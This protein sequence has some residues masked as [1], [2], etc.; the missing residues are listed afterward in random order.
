MSEILINASGL[1]NEREKMVPIF[2]QYLLSKLHGKSN[3]LLIY[4]DGAIY[5]TINTQNTG[6]FRWVYFTSLKMEGIDLLK[7]TISE[8]FY[9]TTVPNRPLTSENILVWKSSLNNEMH[10]ITAG[11]GPYDSLPPVFRKIDNLINEFMVKL[12]DKI[13]QE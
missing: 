7:K 9:T 2:E 11:S 6:N 1:P 13:N 12:N 10:E 3:G 5:T 8:E 4:S